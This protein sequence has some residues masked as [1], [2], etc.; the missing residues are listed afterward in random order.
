M[1]RVTCENCGKERPRPKTFRYVSFEDWVA[2]PFCS[3]E[4]CREAHGVPLPP[5]LGG[6]PATAIV[7]GTKPTQVV[8]EGCGPVILNAGQGGYMRSLYSREGMAAIAATVVSRWLPADFAAEHPAV[9]SALLDALLA[10]PV[11]GYVGC[12][13][14]IESMDLAPDLGLV[15]APALVIA[16]GEDQSVS[17]E[18]GRAVAAGITGAE[19]ELIAGA[20]HLPNISH[21]DRVAHL[22]LDFLTA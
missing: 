9:H 19:F 12:C 22:M 11:E 1:E 21:A 2:D 6:A 3:S 7:S 20:A 8:V 15:T 5:T 16:G 17:P 18:F 13:A 10:T 4:C 14:A